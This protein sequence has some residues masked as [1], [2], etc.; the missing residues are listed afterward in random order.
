MITQ[1]RI[2]R[3]CVL[4]VFI[5]IGYCLFFAISY[6]GDPLA[7]APQLD[8]KE[9]LQLASDLASDTIAEEP[10]YRAVFYPF[11]LSLL[12]SES[13]RV[14]IALVF[15]LCCHLIN[16]F[17]VMRIAKFIWNSDASG[18]LSCLLYLINPAS[19]FYSVQVLDITLAITF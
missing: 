13:A 16:G 6:F 11:L 15:G 1:T 18:W 7:Q 14:Y 2:D 17:L 10:F 3:L 4:G 9:N 12:P 8:A 5:A 19:L